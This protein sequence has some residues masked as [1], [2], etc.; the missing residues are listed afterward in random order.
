MEPIPFWLVAFGII[1]PGVPEILVGGIG[2]SSI[3]QPDPNLAEWELTVSSEM[4]G[5]MGSPDFLP[6]AT[7]VSSPTTPGVAKITLPSPPSG[8]VSTFRV[9]VV[10]NGVDM[11]TPLPYVTVNGQG[12]ISL[13]LMRKGPAL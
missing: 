5:G 13:A 9:S 4:V 3:T 6:V 7:F 8:P 1:V 10:G 12:T 11:V 2:I